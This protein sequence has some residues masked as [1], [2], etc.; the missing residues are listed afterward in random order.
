MAYGPRNK[1][2]NFGGNPD[3]VTLGQVVALPYSALEVV[4]PVVCLNK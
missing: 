1:S 2:I 3:H 4:L